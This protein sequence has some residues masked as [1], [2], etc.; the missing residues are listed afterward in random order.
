MTPLA[1]NK[2]FAHCEM[3]M[4][5]SEEQQMATQEK[6]H[7]PVTEQSKSRVRF[8]PAVRTVLIPAHD[9]PNHAIWYDVNKLMK[10]AQVYVKNI[11]WGLRESKVTESEVYSGDISPCGRGLEVYIQTG[12]LTKRQNRRKAYS[13]ALNRK[14]QTLLTLSSDK[15]EVAERLKTFLLDK[16]KVCRDL[17]RNLG[18]QDS[19]DA[20]S[21]Y[22]SLELTEY[23]KKDNSPSLPSCSTM[24]K[25]KP[26]TSVMRNHIVNHPSLVAAKEPR[27]L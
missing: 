5:S 2:S 17:A 9:I 4:E 6:L 12:E 7:M 24:A 21:I 3:E 15:N 23:T 16:S 10:E 11:S 8:A 14:R 1:T 20:R 25:Q 13:A 27:T 26:I 22:E 18:E 19:I